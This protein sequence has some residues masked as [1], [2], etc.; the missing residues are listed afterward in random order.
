MATVEYIS[1]KDAPIPPKPLSKSAEQS[2]DILHGIKDGYVAKV[3]PDEGQSL[4]GLRASFT[5]VATT[6]KMKIQSWSVDGED[7]LYV[8]KLK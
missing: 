3:T 2:L 4:R 1:E 6:Q 8:K 5:R 7:A